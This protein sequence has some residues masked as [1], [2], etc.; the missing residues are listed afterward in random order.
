MRLCLAPAEC[1]RGM[2]CAHHTSPKPSR[3]GLFDGHTSPS[4]QAFLPL[5]LLSPLQ[6]ILNDL[7]SELVD[8][9][10]QCTDR[11]RRLGE[12][13]KEFAELMASAQAS[14]EDGTAT[15]GRARNNLTRHTDE[16][17]A[18]LKKLATQT[19]TINEQN[20]ALR[21]GAVTTL[22]QSEHALQAVTQQ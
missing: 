14:V 20:N 10:R 6:P 19:E 16:M 2:S 7:K 21:T 22:Q 13:R 5:L 9:I 1:V 11:L 3:Y 12:K 18:E 17:N 8:R 4:V 15:L